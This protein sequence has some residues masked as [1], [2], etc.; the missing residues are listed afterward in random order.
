MVLVEA[1]LRYCWFIG[2]C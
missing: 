1:V 2:L